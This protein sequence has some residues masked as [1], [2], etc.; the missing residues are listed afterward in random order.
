MSNIS[1]NHPGYTCQTSLLKRGWTLKMLEMVF[2]GPDLITVNPHNPSGAPQKLYST[3]IAC[4][5][6]RT[7]WFRNQKRV[8]PTQKR[9]KYLEIEAEIDKTQVVRGSD[10]QAN[11]TL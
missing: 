10:H 1:N 2:G 8:S 6:E 3:E 4:M 5:Y 11:N 7:D 9:K